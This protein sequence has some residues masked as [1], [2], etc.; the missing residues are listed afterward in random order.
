MRLR[1]K[2]IKNK[3]PNSNKKQ[4]RKNETRKKSI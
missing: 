4:R 3:M 1:G 2:G